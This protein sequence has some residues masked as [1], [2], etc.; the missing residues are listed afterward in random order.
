[1]HVYRYPYNNLGQR[2]REVFHAGEC[3][4]LSLVNLSL[5]SYE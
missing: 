3:S 2:T 1:M 4:M 5:S